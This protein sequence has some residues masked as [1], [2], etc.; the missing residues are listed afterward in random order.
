MIPVLA[1][2]VKTTEVSL[3]V[4]IW[5]FIAEEDHSQAAGFAVGVR[6]LVW[7]IDRHGG[8]YSPPF[9]STLGRRM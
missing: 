6:A 9:S 8:I 3:Q 1:T 5:E 4:V 2:S 7:G